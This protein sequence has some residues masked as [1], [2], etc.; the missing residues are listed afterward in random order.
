MLVQRIAQLLCA[1]AVVASGLVVAP[2]ASATA[3]VLDQQANLSMGTS[4]SA[5]VGDI[6]P[7]AQLFV[8]RS[9]GS[10]TSVKVRISRFSNA[11]AANLTIGI[12][13]TQNGIPTG[14]ALAEKVYESNYLGTLSS[15]TVA[16]TLVEAAF[17]PGPEVAAGNVYAIQLS[18]SDPNPGYRWFAGHYCMPGMY[19][20]ASSNA[21]LQSEFPMAFETYV[22]NTPV[23]TDVLPAP[24]LFKAT[25]QSGSASVTF[26]MCRGSGAYLHPEIDLGLTDLEFDVNGSNSWQ[27]LGRPENY[28]PVTI[29]G[30]TNNVSSSIRLRAVAGSSTSGASNPISVVPENPAVV[31]LVATPITGGMSIAFTPCRNGG[32]PLTN[33]EYNISNSGWVRPDPVVTTSPITIS[34]L[35]DGQPITVQLR[36]TNA[37]MTGASSEVLE[38]VIPGVG[39]TPVAGTVT[40]CT[41]P[42]A[43]PGGNGSSGG[44]DSGVPQSPVQVVS[45][46][47]VVTPVITPVITPPAQTPSTPSSPSIVATTTSP[48]EPPSVVRVTKPAGSTIAQAPVV[49]VSVSEPIQ[50]QVSGLRASTPMSV[51]RWLNGRWQ[52]VG[53]VTSGP[54]GGVRTPKIT[55]AKPGAFMVRIGSAKAGWK[56]VRVVAG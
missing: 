19:Y 12:Y 53:A 17:T 56:F 33:I 1:A 25:P 41:L 13:A 7:V 16:A 30:L 48:E 39:G 35:T 37:T 29:P 9:S 47:P 46:Q 6:M 36:A 8:A 10:L 18:T 11:P 5:F 14:P 52:I 51:Q 44:S 31:S 23:P 54:G 55:A 21:W 3:P 32:G 27:P 38:N 2:P 43:A 28:S 42:D 49:K 50:V 45:E 20:S 34:G 4:A 24:L 40:T 22:D 26:A 15:D